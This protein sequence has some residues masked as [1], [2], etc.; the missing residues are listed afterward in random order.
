MADE[1]ELSFLIDWEPATIFGQSR[2]DGSCH[3]G[4]MPFMALALLNEE[5]WE[6][7]M[8]RQYHHDLEGFLLLKLGFLND[9][10]D[11]PALLRMKATPSHEMGWILFCDILPSIHESWSPQSGSTGVEV[12]EDAYAKVS[13][14][15]TYLDFWKRVKT[16][17]NLPRT[18]E[19]IP[20]L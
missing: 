8:K 18:K 2:H 5:Y 3:I 16:L 9:I 17:A 4:T 12:S 14:K 1:H 11:G 7:K 13:S 15:E 6:G 20:N 10:E 19:L